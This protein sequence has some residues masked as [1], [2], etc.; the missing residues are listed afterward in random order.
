MSLLFQVREMRIRTAT[1]LRMLRLHSPEQ[2]AYQSSAS[3]GEHRCSSPGLVADPSDKPA[4][5][6]RFTA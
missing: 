5:L 3:A 1:R 4:M 6:G 2:E